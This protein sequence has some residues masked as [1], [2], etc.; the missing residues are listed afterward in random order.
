MCLFRQDLMYS[1]LNKHID[2]C[3]HVVLLCL[4]CVVVWCYNHCHCVHGSCSCGSLHFGE[5]VVS[6]YHDL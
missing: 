4:C 5:G 1:C 2:G 3:M 6:E